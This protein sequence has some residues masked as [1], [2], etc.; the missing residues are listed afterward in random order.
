MEPTIEQGHIDVALTD[1]AVSLFYESMNFTANEIA[2]PITVSS[3]SGKYFIVDPREAYTDEHEMELMYGQIATELDFVIG[4]GNYGTNLIGK[5]HLLPD[6]IMLNSDTAVRER[7][8]GL[9]Y[10][11]MNLGIRRERR[12]AALITDA[13]TYPSADHFFVVDT[14]WDMP[15]S[16]PLIDIQQ[17]ARVMA[18]ACGVVPNRMVCS[19]RTYDALIR[20]PLIRQLIRSSPARAERYLEAGEIGDQLF[21]LRLIKAGAV[22]DT[23]APLET[24]NMAFIWENFLSDAGTDWAL[25]YFFDP[26]PGLF[27]S[28]FG[29]QFV[30]NANEIAPGLMGRVRVYRDDAREGTWYEMRSDWQLK[31]T[32][33]AAGVVMTGTSG[34]SSS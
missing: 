11:A 4:K 5:R 22:Y 19:P 23:A 29:A 27:T 24:K 8:K 9:T 2:P 3:Q 13:D 7:Q 33:P 20:N 28:G 14:P 26:S 18:L 16:D 32:N 31:I 1:F 34:A 12:L 21:S 17:G 15:N 10:I 30:W 25:L 6:G